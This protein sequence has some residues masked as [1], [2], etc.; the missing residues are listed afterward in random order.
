MIYDSRNGCEAMDAAFF[1]AVNLFD[2]W[3][4]DRF[5]FIYFFGWDRSWAG[6]GCVR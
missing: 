1:C 4:V 5:H 2:E 6:V 3:R